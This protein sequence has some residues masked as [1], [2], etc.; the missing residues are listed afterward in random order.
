MIFH[1]NRFVAKIV[2]QEKSNSEGETKESIVRTIYRF[3]TQQRGCI[4]SS[5]QNNN[6]QPDSTQNTLSD[7]EVEQQ[8][9]D[10]QLLF[11]SFTPLSPMPT[12]DETAELARSVASLEQS[13]DLCSLYCN[14]LWVQFMYTLYN[15]RKEYMF[16]P[17][18]QMA[19]EVHV[20]SW[21]E[22][23]ANVSR[24][25]AH[26][27]HICARHGLVY[28]VFLSRPY[29][30]KLDLLYRQKA[31]TMNNDDVGGDTCAPTTFCPSS[32][33]VSSGYTTGSEADVIPADH[34]HDPRDPQDPPDPQGLP[35][36][37]RTAPP[38]ES[39]AAARAHAV[40]AALAA[41]A[42][43]GGGGGGGGVNSPAPTVA[44]SSDTSSA[45][46]ERANHGAA[47]TF[48]ITNKMQRRW[49]SHKQYQVG[50]KYNTFPHGASDEERQARESQ[51][52]DQGE[53]IGHQ[54]QFASAS[55]NSVD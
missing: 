5:V 51:L 15:G 11:A 4:K 44:P 40:A 26:F 33:G 6:V 3:L 21:A 48:V 10:Y 36:D 50:P 2:R 47:P 8:K 31:Q 9:I 16:V 42:A 37:R 46:V 39:R 41:A 1:M 45:N 17:E 7:S 55:S 14:P 43:C 18:M 34:L 53:Y 24:L 35:P 20:R 22:R 38:T 13:D 49:H 28:D 27:Y 25:I 29:S 19:F 30:Q 54:F 52:R 32:S 23:D 12:Y